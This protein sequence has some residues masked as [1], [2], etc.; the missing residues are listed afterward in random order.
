MKPI[1]ASAGEPMNIIVELDFARE[2]IT[3]DWSLTAWATNGAVTVRHT[4]DISTD[5]L[6]YIERKEDTQNA[7]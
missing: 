4:N 5:S 7:E 3:P 2:N 1:A 6:P